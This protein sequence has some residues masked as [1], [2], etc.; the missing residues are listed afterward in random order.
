MATVERCHEIVEELR[1]T[2]RSL[3]EVCTDDEVNDKDVSDAIDVELFECRECSWW[4]D[5]DEESENAEDGPVC[6]G[7]TGEA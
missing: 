1:G 3:H 7:C 2:C 4:C 5:W 6:M